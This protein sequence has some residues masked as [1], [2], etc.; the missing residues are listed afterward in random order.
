MTIICAVQVSLTFTNP[1]TLAPYYQPK[2][3]STITNNP[4]IRKSVNFYMIS[5]YF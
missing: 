2:P 4:K 1:R 5:K 3:N